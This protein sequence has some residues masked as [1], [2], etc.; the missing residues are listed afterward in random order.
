MHSIE[1][2]SRLKRQAKKI[3]NSAAKLNKEKNKSESDASDKPITVSREDSDETAM[4]ST[5]IAYIFALNNDCLGLIFDYLSMKDLHS[6]GQTCK[7][8]Q[9]IAGEYFERNYKSSEKFTSSDGIYTVYSDQNGVINQRT[10]TSAFNRFINYIS[11]YYENLEPLRYIQA[12]S[13][14]FKSIN[15]IYL[16]CLILNATKIECLKKLLAK[17]EIIQIRQC[18]TDGDFYDILLKWCGNVKRIYV[19]DDLGYILDENGNPWL[20]QEYPMLEHLQ[21]TPRFSFKINELDAFFQRNPGVQSFSTSSRCLWENRHELLQSTIK[22]D[23]LEIQILD[24]YHRHLINMQSICAL[25]NQFY[26]RGFY[27]RLHLSVKCVDQQCSEHVITLMALEI[28][29][30]KQFTGC[31]KLSQ[32]TKLKEL[33][34]NNSI[35]SKDIEMFATNLVNLERLSL[36]DTTVNDIE[37]FVRC[38]AKLHRLRVQFNEGSLN[39]AALNRERGKLTGARKLIIYVSNNVFLATKWNTANGVT[40][41]DFIEMR[42]ASQW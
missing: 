26:G 7:A 16:V 38:L 40:N 15:Q 35:N 3:K 24:N 11:H 4:T 5:S 29:S 27:K 10:Q 14:E 42:R 20:L 13:D 19:Q 30:I 39:L 2:I 18:T 22:L 6:F 31:F 12:H 9:Q 1:R 25:L 28:L 41:F 33:E 23:K 32:L 36:L 37:P 17:I 21:L 8:F 34:I